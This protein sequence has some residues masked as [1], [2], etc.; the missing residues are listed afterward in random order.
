[1][2]RAAAVFFALALGLPAGAGATAS[3]LARRRAGTSASAARL[4]SEF[5]LLTEGLGH[6]F[7]RAEV[8]M[9]LRV[10]AAKA[11]LSHAADRL[12]TEQGSSFGTQAFRTYMDDVLP[13]WHL[14]TNSSSAVPES[15][16]ES[17]AIVND[18]HGQLIINTT[19][20][21][22]G[23]CTSSSKAANES[24]AGLFDFAAP[25]ELNSTQRVFTGLSDVV[26]H[27]DEE[28]ERA[29]QALPGIM[30]G[31]LG[32][33]LGRP[34]LAAA[35]GNSSAAPAAGGNSSGNATGAGERN[36]SGIYDALEDLA[37]ILEMPSLGD[38]RG[39]PAS[40]DADA[41]A[42]DPLRDFF[43]LPFAGMFGGRGA[44]PRS[45]AASTGDLF[46][47]LFNRPFGGAFDDD[48]DDAPLFPAVSDPFH[49]IFDRT[50]ANMFGDD[51]GPDELGAPPVPAANSTAGG[52]FH[53]ISNHTLFGMLDDGAAPGNM[54]SDGTW[55]MTRI[56]NGH[57]VQETRTCR[58]GN[59]TTVRRE[60]D[61]P[62][63][64]GPGPSSF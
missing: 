53:D 38:T 47:D 23:N 2:V 30:R 22:N 31:L 16:T 54:T 43:A 17:T 34:G 39:A 5:N 11:F 28:M 15:V 7:N 49:D 14:F 57:G 8:P 1:M 3:F 36:A 60:F 33:A 58:A 61:G 40:P 13:S 51:F 19:R 12:E 35:P 52:P 56:E 32:A 10:P 63:A 45:G 27:I 50:F 18:G 24:L 62:A 29:G 6:L 26:H 41:G 48:E 4:H 64:E 21:T 55:S 46:Q 59:C 44:A 42:F 25:E 9:A 20:C 37:G